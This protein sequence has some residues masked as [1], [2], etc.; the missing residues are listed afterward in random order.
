MFCDNLKPF[1]AAALGKWWLG[2]DVGAAALLIGILLM[3]CGVTLVSLE[4]ARRET[5]S[6]NRNSRVAET[7]GWAAAAANVSLDTE[8]PDQDPWPGGLTTWQI[9]L[10]RFGSAAVGLMAIAAVG[11]SAPA[12]GGGGSAPPK[13]AA[14]GGGARD[15]R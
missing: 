13:A 7:W 4:K 8:R 10:I 3:A 12:A 5:H 2:E 9:N 11:V 1:L 6:A 15:G 14:A